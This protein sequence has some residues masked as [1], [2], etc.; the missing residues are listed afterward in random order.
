LIKSLILIVWN[1]PMILYIAEK[2]SLRRALAEALPKPHS[3]GD[4]FIT[5]GSGD[6]ITGVRAAVEKGL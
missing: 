5:V 6:D 1:Q 4:G 3:K 2:P